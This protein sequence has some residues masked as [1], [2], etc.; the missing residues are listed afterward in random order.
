MEVCPDALDQLQVPL[1][2]VIR[3]QVTIAPHFGG[4]V[5]CRGSRLHHVAVEGDPGEAWWRFR[6]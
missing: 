3:H 1:M 6:G 2:E 4:Q 5:D